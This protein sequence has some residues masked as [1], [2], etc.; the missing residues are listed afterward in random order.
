MERVAKE[1]DRNT[2]ESLPAYVYECVCVCV[3]LVKE[4]GVIASL[5]LM[6]DVSEM[7]SERNKRRYRE[8]ENEEER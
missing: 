5:I 8:K 2:P 4:R 1:V 7:C 6:L 3:L